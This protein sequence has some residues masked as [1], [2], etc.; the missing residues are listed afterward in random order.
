MMNLFENFKDVMN[1]QTHLKE[2]KEKLKDVEVIGTSGG[3]LVKVTLNGTFFLTNIEIDPIAVDSRDVKML[4]DLIVS[5][6]CDAMGKLEEK[7]QEE[8]GPFAKGLM[9]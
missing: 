3:G 6:H 9:G 2:M 5:A 4:Q 7:M 8:L 1:I